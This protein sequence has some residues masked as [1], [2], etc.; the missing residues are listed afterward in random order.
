LQENSSLWLK[1]LCG[2]IAR[3]RRDGFLR[4]SRAPLRAS[5]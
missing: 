3:E 2:A 4:G 1:K 5:G